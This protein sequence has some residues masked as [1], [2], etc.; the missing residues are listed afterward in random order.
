MDP[1]IIPVMGSQSMCLFVSIAIFVATSLP[2]GLLAQQPA[3]SE[4]KSGGRVEGTASQLVNLRHASGPGRRAR[5]RRLRHQRRR[6]L[7]HVVRLHEP[8]LRGSRSICRSAPSNTF[9]PGGDR[10]QPTHFTP[11]RHKDV[12]KVTVPK[13]FGEQQARLEADRAR[14]DAAG[15]RHAEAGVADRSPAHD[16]RRQQ[17]EDQLEPAARGHRPT[18]ANNRRPPRHR[19]R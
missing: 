18:P 11:R 12:F 10:G 5:L 17:R 16:A 9:E 6:L 8:Q 2:G 7:Q 13:D 14:P 19:R 3:L 15:R 1:S 4:P